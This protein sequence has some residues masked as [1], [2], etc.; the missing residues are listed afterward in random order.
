MTDDNNHHW[1]GFIL[2][3]GSLFCLGTWPALL[4]LASLYHHNHDNATTNDRQ[5]KKQSHLSPQH[6]QN[7]A[8]T[9]TMTTTEP[10]HGQSV[11]NDNT[12]INQHNIASTTTAKNNSIPSRESSSSLSISSSIQSIQFACYNYI[13]YSTSYVIISIIPFVL[14]HIT[15]HYHNDSNEQQ[16]EQEFSFFM[17]FPLVI[18]SMFGGMLLSLGNLSMQWSTCIYNAPLTTVLA[19]Q[20][21]LCVVFG[22]TINYYL[23][24]YKTNHASLLLYGVIMFLFAIILAT[25][26]Q[27]QY[28]QQQQQNDKH[29]FN[30]NDSSSYSL[31]EKATTVLS[32]QDDDDDNQQL[33][34]IEI[35]PTYNNQLHKL[36]KKNDDSS[37]LQQYNETKNEHDGLFIVTNEKISKTIHPFHIAAPTTTTTSSLYYA[38]N[39]RH[40][41]LYDDNN[42]Y[43]IEYHQ[44]NNTNKK[45]KTV[46]GIIIAIFGGICFGFFSPAFN[47]S[48]NDPFN[49]SNNINENKNSQQM[50]HTLISN[51]WFSIAFWIT[52]CIGNISILLYMQSYTKTR[53]DV[54]NHDDD[55][56]D[57]QRKERMYHRTHEGN[58]NICQYIHQLWY[59]Y[60]HYH[61]YHSPPLSTRSIAITVNNTNRY[62]NKGCFQHQQQRYYSIIAGIVCAM[63]NI[64]QFQ[65]GQYVGYATADLVQA[66][67]IVSTIYDIYIFHEFQYIQ[68]NSFIFL[69]LVGMYIS[70]I[71]GI[72]LLAASSL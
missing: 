70:Y 5:Q 7:N 31:V 57:L 25:I 50:L 40:T 43:N 62:N 52:S 22:T 36:K 2:L 60:I 45:N 51:V 35:N 32:P 53:Y 18:T 3:L 1:I 37:L 63:G 20:S 69:L 29:H 14:Y 19:I 68:Y 9:T 66:Y 46:V 44:L 54:D 65:G 58:R 49:W 10:M 8:T 6:Q 47:I 26:T 12:I 42:H 38:M 27:Y 16:E 59:D 67:P 4:R 39:H 17:S 33:G 11:D 28:I 23:E 64:L 41:S 34:N 13:D 24:P 72:I 56:D 48:V 55:D 61:D 15:H 71:T 30:N 21:S